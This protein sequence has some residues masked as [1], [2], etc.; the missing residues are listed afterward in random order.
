[1]SAFPSSLERLIEA[2]ARLPGVGS[3]S[4]QRMAFYI[5]SLDPAEAKSFADA[6]KLILSGVSEVIIYN[7]YFG[8]T[9]TL[10]VVRCIG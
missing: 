4:A 9:P 10:L 7:E 3:K 5:L 2:F 1:M 6:I 8:A